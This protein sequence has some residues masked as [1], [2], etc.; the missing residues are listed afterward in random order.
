MHADKNC[1]CTEGE[2]ASYARAYRLMYL[3]VRARARVRACVRACV[4]VCVRACVQHTQT[5][6]VVGCCDSHTFAHMHYDPE[7][8]RTDSGHGWFEA[9]D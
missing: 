4:Y 9:K 1:P 6:G 2:N 7:I 5:H 8:I 3:C